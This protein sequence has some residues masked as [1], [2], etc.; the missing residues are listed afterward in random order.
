MC[1]CTHARSHTCTQDHTNARKIT[2]MH[3]RSRTCMHA[4]KITYMHVHN[5]WFRRSEPQPSPIL[6]R[7]VHPTYAHEQ[8][9]QCGGHTL[10]LWRR[11]RRPC[12]SCCGCR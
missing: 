2:H 12:C 6:H 8:P 3:A 10:C 1:I 5:R 9:H 11:R 4:R 7:P